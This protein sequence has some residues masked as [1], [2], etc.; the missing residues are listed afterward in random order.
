MLVPVYDGRPN[1]QGVKLSKFPTMKRIDT[2]DSRKNRVV[3]ERDCVLV[4]FTIN[5]FTKKDLKDDVQFHTDIFM[6]F[7]IQAVILVAKSTRRP[8]PYKGI[9]PPTL[10]ISAPVSRIWLYLF[11]FLLFTILEMR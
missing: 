8:K 9:S 7:N 4:A 10:P 1:D 6:A 11:N 5:T 3:L 2:M